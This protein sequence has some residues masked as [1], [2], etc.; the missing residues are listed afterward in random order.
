M[1]LDSWPLHSGACHLAS[2]ML[3]QLMSGW[4]DMLAVAQ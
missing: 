3:F 1:G 2:E 4:P